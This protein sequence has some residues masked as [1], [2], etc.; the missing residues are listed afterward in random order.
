METPRN[1]VAYISGKYRAPTI[2]GIHANI[3]AARWVAVDA[4]L[5]GMTA[6]CPH[7]N[8]AY[9]DGIA[10]D[11]AFLDGD[12]ELLRRCDLLIL[13]PGWET[14]EGAKIERQEAVRRGIP[15]YVWE[16]EGDA[17]RILTMYTADHP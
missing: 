1:L 6:L 17:A 15:T 9:M 14:S 10:P 4:W 8:S 11:T 5:A 16:T 13:V 12:L 2:H 3:E 7:M